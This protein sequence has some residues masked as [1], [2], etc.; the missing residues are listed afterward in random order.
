MYTYKDYKDKKCD[1][2]TY[3]HQFVTPSISTA[4]KTII[5]EHK[6]LNSAWPFNDIPTE[7][8]D[9]IPIRLMYNK[10]LWKSAGGAPLAPADIVCIA[11]A[12]AEQFRRD[13][14]LQVKETT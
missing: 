11:K 14:S 6:I 2:H 9:T 1:H 3:Y 7:L 5:G 12:A 8:W 4:V 10:Q 13:E